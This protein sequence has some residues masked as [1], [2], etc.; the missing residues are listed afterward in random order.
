MFKVS[1]FN[2]ESIKL[3]NTMY[4]LIRESDDEDRFDDENNNMK[5][6]QQAAAAAAAASKGNASGAKAN[7]PSASPKQVSQKKQDQPLNL[8]A[9]NMM[10]NQ[11]LKKKPTSVPLKSLDVE[12]E[13][14]LS[15]VNRPSFSIIKKGH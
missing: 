14:I 13:N 8:L 2:L 3:T 9:S 1:I 4:D 6:K 11:N 10:A 5:R 15:Q 12:L 7:T